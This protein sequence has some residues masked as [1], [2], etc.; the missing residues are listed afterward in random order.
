MALPDFFTIG[1]GTP[2]IW[3]E[4]GATGISLTVT[5]TLS[6]DALADGSGR[7]GA[8]ADLGATFYKWF[9]LWL[10]VETGT[11]PTAANIVELF[12]ACSHDNTNWPGKVTGSDAAYP[13]TVAANKKQLGAPASI[14]IATNDA[15]TVLYQQPVL[16]RPAA[17]YVAPVVVNSLGQAFRDESTA[18]NNDSRVVLVPLQDQVQD[19]A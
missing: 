16:W 11:A 9:L 10:I 8:S 4:A 7:M 14:L 2:V 19:S 1:Q 6:L 18:T 5:K 17:R 15:N 13:T 12:M 3:G